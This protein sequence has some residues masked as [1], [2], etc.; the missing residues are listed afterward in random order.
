[1]MPMPMPHGPPSSVQHHPQ[2]G[3]LPQQ[4]P[5]VP[6]G[7]VNSM[8]LYSFNHSGRPSQGG[9]PPSQMGAAAAATEA[10]GLPPA[11][12]QATHITHMASPAQAPQPAHSIMRSRSSGS[13]E[14][15]GGWIGAGHMAPQQQQQQQVVLP[16]RPAIMQQH[17][18]VGGGGATDSR[19][20]VIR[21]T[22]NLG[23]LGL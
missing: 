23:L 8:N 18:V 6:P 14:G 19:E 5:S 20:G 21:A 16:P 22:G 2:Y 7:G 10:W 17:V 15:G 11:P 3:M 13:G 1:M 9:D 4:Y 12:L